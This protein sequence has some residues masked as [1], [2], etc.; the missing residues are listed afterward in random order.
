MVTRGLFPEL[1]MV[2][3]AD[4]G[5]WII[6]AVLCGGFAAGNVVLATRR[7]VRLDP[8]SILRNA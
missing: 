7:I 1:V 6:V 2:S 8:W 3:A 4:T 5:M